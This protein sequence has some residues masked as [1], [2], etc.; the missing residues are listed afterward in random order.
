MPIAPRGFV[1][2]LPNSGTLFDYDAR[3]QRV[4]AIE[5][6]MSEPGFWDKPEAA[7]ATVAELKS[8]SSI[9]KPLRE[10]VKAVGDLDVMLELADEDEGW[11]PK[12]RPSSIGWKPCSKISS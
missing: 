7:Q 4:T 8:V 1:R 3:Q 11:R 10:L 9:V 2:G 12:F 5:A 6:Q